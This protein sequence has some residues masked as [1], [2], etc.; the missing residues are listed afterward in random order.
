MLLS[1]YYKGFRQYL[2]LEKNVSA[3]TVE[4]YLSDISKISL[5]C[6][7]SGRNPDTLTPDNEFFQEFIKWLSLSGVKPST[8]ARVLSGIR[9]FY[10]Y[11]LLEKQI[12][13]NPAEFLE[14]PRLTRKL[15]SVLSY[16]EIEKILAQIDLSKEGG[17]RN[18]VIIELLFACGLRVSELVQLTIGNISFKEEWILITGKG[19]KQRL[20]PVSQN[21]LSLIKIYLETER[22]HATPSAKD[23]EILFLNKRGGRLSRVYIF[24]MLKDLAL[25]A[26]IRKSIS[27]HTL[28]HSF[29][30]SLV[31]HGADLRAVQD[32]LGHES[33]TTTEIYTHLDKK[34]LSH[35]I[36]TYHPRAGKNT[37]K[38][39]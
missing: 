6:D 24:M 15:P 12:T 11:L 35:V 30:T 13:H 17:F 7:E 2:Q 22:Y 25:K 38:Q 10:A 26:G 8:Q 16:E 36:D 27:P 9:A 19:N 31:T 37:K 33:I 29:A 34:H 4:A 3:H 5:F 39:N 23:R 14:F 1:G 28:R 21:A 20:V 32:M 18:K